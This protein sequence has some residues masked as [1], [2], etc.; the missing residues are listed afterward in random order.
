MSFFSESDRILFVAP[1]PDDESLGGGGLLQ[2]VFAAQIPVRILFATSGDNNPW[3]QRFWEQRW[4]I[5]PRERVRW[6]NKRQQEALAAITTLGGSLDCA[7]F[8]NFPDQGIT[9]LLM[10]GVAELFGTFADEIR[11]FNPSILVIPAGFDAHPDHSALCVIISLAFNSIENPG[12]RILEYLVHQPKIPI[13]RHAAVLRLDSEE[14]ERKRKAIRCHETQV[15]LGASRFMR[16]AKAEE[17]FYEHVPIGAASDTG[18][19]LKAQIREDVLNLLIGTRKLDKL[20]TEVFLAFRS[21]TAEMLR[22]RVSVPMFS[23]PAQISDVRSGRHLYDGVATWA[24]SRLAI[25]VPIIG[26]SGLNALF[27]KFSSWTLFFDRSGWFQ[28]PMNSEQPVEKRL[29]LTHLS[30]LLQ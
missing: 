21:E 10:R 7:R 22:W 14:I 24:G 4:K 30:T 28:V 27:V 23:G 19:V 11:A 2:R 16:L 18:P 5:G 20:G 6:G 1:H 9:S 25:G 3:A 17:A 15:A 29:P 26:V 12:L 8:L 13:Q